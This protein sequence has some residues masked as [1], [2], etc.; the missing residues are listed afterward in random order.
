MTNLKEYDKENIHENCRKAIQPYLANP[1]FNPE[2]IYAKS[3]AA[4]GLCAWVINI[5]KFYE[6]FKE[7]EPK[8]LALEDANAELAA[9]Q[10][11]LAG[12]QA[13][14]TELEKSLGKL[15]AKFQ[16]AT[17][18]KLRCQAEADATNLTIELAN[19]LVNGLASENVRWA[20]SIK[21]LNIKKNMLPGD[22]LLVSSFVSY[23]GC[24]TKSYR[25]DLIAKYWTKY[26]QSKKDEIPTSDELQPLS[27]LTDDASIAGWN[28]E[29]LPND[30]MSIEN[31]TI[32][33]NCER[34]P[35]I[36]DPQ[37]QGIKWIKNRYQEN[38]KVGSRI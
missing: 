26:L 16:E 19:R 12:I 14:I 17:E 20:E 3:T 25:V 36:I 29:G 13:K 38:L 34:W 18:A 21:E 31:A 30:L 24:F 10:D 35:L 5:M 33:T 1:E 7:V 9:A 11:K 2:F 4:A 22:T 27:L 8:R 37:L 28:N 23:L 6:V 32:L 15:T